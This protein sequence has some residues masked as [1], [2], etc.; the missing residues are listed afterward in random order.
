MTT[1]ECPSCHATAGR[2]HT[3]Y[4]LDRYRGEPDM[5][6]QMTDDCG[7]GSLVALSR[8]IDESP[9]YEGVSTE[10]VDWRRITKLVEEAGEV[11]EAYAGWLGENP[12]KGKTHTL[13]DVEHEL[14]DVAVSALGAIVHLRGNAPDCEVMGD[15]VRHIESRAERA[16]LSPRAVGKETS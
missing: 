14:L 15:L 10:A 8:W 6:D 9:A 12:R 13:A 4:C 1:S 11:I 3:E 7:T 2:P 5:S 16:G